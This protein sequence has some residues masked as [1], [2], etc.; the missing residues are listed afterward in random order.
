MRKKKRLPVAVEPEEFILLLKNTKHR[1]HRVAFILGY[2]SG[3]RISE[4]IN[5]E[6]RDIDLVKKS[7][8]VREGK[9][10]TIAPLEET[11]E[12]TQVNITESD[13]HSGRGGVG[14]RE[15]GGKI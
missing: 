3:L 12:G 9:G 4:V 6:K 1:N 8:L 15:S 13:I 11:E 7:I 5:L 10:G 2:E 14:E